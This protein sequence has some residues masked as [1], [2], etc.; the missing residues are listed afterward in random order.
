M[1]FLPSLLNACLMGFIG[2]CIFF[3]ILWIS[4]NKVLD[5]ECPITW[6]VCSWVTRMTLVLGG[7]Y[8]VA[9][10]N[11]QLLLSCLFGFILGRWL[12]SRA[13]AGCFTAV[14]AP[15]KLETGVKRAS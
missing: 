6:F 11:W 10:S 3:T 7:F 4:A 5:S 14:K 8:W 15:A 1:S 13:V 12:I 2:G 9:N